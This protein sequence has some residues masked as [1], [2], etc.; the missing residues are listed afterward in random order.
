VYTDPSLA[1]YAGLCR[2][3]FGTGM[4]GGEV[5]FYDLGETGLDTGCKPLSPSGAEKICV[6]LRCAETAAGNRPATAAHPPVTEKT[7]RD[8]LDNETA[9]LE[10]L[11]GILTGKIACGDI[12][13]GTAGER[14]AGLVKQLDYLHI[15]FPD[16]YKADVRDT[17]FL[18]RVRVELEYF[19]KTLGVS[20]VSF[21]SS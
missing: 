3:Y 18:K 15:H 2:A 12:A 6:E 8:F 1:G 11:K 9:M 7:V 20:G 21:P 14:I 5:G 10:E 13:G 17:G 19:L 16:G 4:S